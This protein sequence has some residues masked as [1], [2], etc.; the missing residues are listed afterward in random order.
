MDK[1]NISVVAEQAQ[2]SQTTVSRVLNH[3]PLVREATAERVRRVIA[4]LGY[5]PSELARGLRSN[6]TKTIGV[7]VSNILNPFFTGMVRGIEDIA[8]HADYNI[9]LCNTDEQPLKEQRYLETLLSKRVDGLIIAS[10]GLQE[11]YA[12]RLEQAPVVFVD[13][14]PAGTNASRFDAVLVD[15]RGGSRLAVEHLIDEGYRRI[16]IIA[17]SNV[18]TTGLERLQGYQDALQAR[19]LP[20][21]EEFIRIGD[22]LGHSAFDHMQHLLSASPRCDAIFASNNIIL[23]GV[24]KALSVARITCPDEMGIAAFDDMD[25]MEYCS[26]RF[27]A[28]AQPTYRMGTLAMEMLLER[29]AAEQT[30]PPR[31]VVL[32]VQLEIRDSSRCQAGGLHPLANRACL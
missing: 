32:P 12:Q 11:D 29:I 15:N 5:R 16:A 30:L 18:G 14:R 1:I 26:P 21:C 3:S 24:L 10:T 23:M 2:V 13:R 7:I 22:F 25:W 19:G 28:V 9:V 17:G 4:Q 27:T 8:N 6:E 31:E 20:V